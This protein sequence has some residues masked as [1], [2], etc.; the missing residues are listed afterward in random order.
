MGYRIEHLSICGHDISEYVIEIDP[1]AKANMKFAA[2]ELQRLIYKACGVK[3]PI[4]AGYTKRV[5]AFEFYTVDNPEYYIEGFKY[6]VEGSRVIFQSA[7]ER[8]S[9]NAVWFFLENELG[10]DGLTNGDSVL[11]ESDYI[12]I[13]QTVYC[14][15]TPSFATYYPSHWLDPDAVHTGMSGWITDRGTPTAEEIAGGVTSVYRYGKYGFAMHGMEKNEWGGVVY[16]HYRQ[17]CYSDESILD[18]IAGD[19]IAHIE[20]T[21]SVT[22]EPDMAID[23]SQGDN[24]TYC[25]CKE[26]L[27][28]YKNEGGTYSGSV[29]CFANALSE[30]VNEEFPETKFC[31]YAYHGTNKPCKTVPSDNV[32]ITVCLD[33]SCSVHPIDGS[34]CFGVSNNDYIDETPLNNNDYGEW[35]KGW[36]ELTPHLYVWEYYL[37][38]MLQSPIYYSVIYDD[39]KF[40]TDIGIEGYYANI[41]ADNIGFQRVMDQ[42]WTYLYWNPDTTEDKFY[43]MW[44]HFTEKVYGDA[45]P[46]VSEYARL[47]EDAQKSAGA[48]RNC[49]GQND[50]TGYGYY[51]FDFVINN[52]SNVRDLAAE[53]V[54]LADSRREEIFVCRLFGSAYYRYIF[55]ASDKF[56]SGDEV[57]TWD[58]LLGMWD[59]M[60]SLFAIGEIDLATYR[61]GKYNGF[62]T[63]YNT[64]WGFGK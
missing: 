8:G 50:P 56:H 27:K 26:C 43:E 9:K 49:W 2:S 51:N 18:N 21:V 61:S 1:D 11:R 10:R 52:F 28:S 45:A 55:A 20:N 63:V 12:D 24:F 33:G 4:T 6:F 59:E 48:C 31:I 29:V 23:V 19:I 41:N 17:I 15:K 5:C 53:A 37:N 40:L 54:S 42:I 32:L 13:P 39:Y 64:T 46:A 22:G 16:A 44:E 34:E 35:L 57:F 30:I 25:T 62:D 7:K 14:E 3:L 38:C 58:Y 60:T 47:L 36:R